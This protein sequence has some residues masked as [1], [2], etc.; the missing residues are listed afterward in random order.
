MKRC[1]LAG[2]FKFNFACLKLKIEILARNNLN[3][4][5]RNRVIVLDFSLTCDYV[6]ICLLL[7][8]KC[9]CLLGWHLCILKYVETQH[10]RL[11]LNRI[12]AD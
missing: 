7:M 2:M 11:V 1:F 3:Q 5:K 9:I 10:M 6:G 12:E 4:S 8:N